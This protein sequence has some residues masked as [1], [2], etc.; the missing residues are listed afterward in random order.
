MGRGLDY[1]KNHLKVS[2]KDH[3]SA[4][5][6]IMCLLIV[7]LNGLCSNNLDNRCLILFSIL[8]IQHYF[9]IQRMNPYVILIY[10]HLVLRYRA[11]LKMSIVRE[12][13]I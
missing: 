2:L 5:H 11:L 4:N 6:S 10:G 1:L 12:M 8:N 3:F 13:E 7:H 9:I